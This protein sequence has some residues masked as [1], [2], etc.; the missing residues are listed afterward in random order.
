M[1]ARKWPTALKAMGTAATGAA[2]D[3]SADPFAPACIPRT[4]G[5]QIA[6]KGSTPQKDTDT[7]AG[8]A[9][10]ARVVDLIVQV[11][12]RM[13]PKMKPKMNPR[14]RPLRTM[15]T[16]KGPLSRLADL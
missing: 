16:I 5:D 6:K 9:R 2:R 10:T 14:R 12:G 1:A 3:G 7:V 13:N 11:R 15:R 4:V 8:G